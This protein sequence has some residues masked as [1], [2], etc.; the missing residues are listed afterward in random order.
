MNRSVSCAVLS[1]LALTASVLAQ[2][3]DTSS[4]AAPVATKSAK[5]AN[6]APAQKGAAMSESDKVLYELG[7]LLSM[8]LDN[9]RLSDS[10]FT[11][12]RAGL[13]D[14]FH[15]RADT[16]EAQT[17]MTKVQALQR[18]RS[19]ALAVEEKQRGEAFLAKAAAE[20]GAKKTSSGLIYISETEGSGSTPAA[21]DQVKVNY[22]GSLIDGTVFD[23]SYK[24]G[25]AATFGVSS[26]IPCWTE[27]LQLMKVGGKD[28]VICPAAL[29]YG[30]RGALPK[31]KP[32]AT[33]VFQIELLDVKAA[34]AGGASSA[35]PGA[36]A[37][38]NGTEGTPAQ[39]G[40]P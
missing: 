7:V 9:F 21:E 12:V 27:A 20:P 30:D 37:S 11:T 33:L 25:Q 3:A 14:G 18:T 8:S 13:S 34:A 5:A 36:G 39:G 35:T 32:G 40:Q 10:E 19:A 29:A 23:S 31:I 6:G 16:T 4:A 24:R 17:Y 15:H 1:L 28:R 2:A 26:V 38:A 22:E